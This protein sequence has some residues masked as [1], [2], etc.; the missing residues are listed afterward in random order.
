MEGRMNLSDEENELYTKLFVQCDLDGF[1]Y[2]SGNATSELF[3]SSGLS[4]D[5]LF[6]IWEIADKTN[7][8]QLDFAGFCV[9]LRLIGHVQ[10]YGPHALRDCDVLMNK[11][12]EELPFFS[13]PGPSS[14]SNI[15]QTGYDVDPALYF[16]STSDLDG[17]KYTFLQ[18]T[19]DLNDFLLGE[20]AR[21]FYLNTTNLSQDDLMHLWSLADI[22]KDGRLSFR[23]FCVMQKL[24][25]CLKL[26]GTMPHML[27]NPLLQFLEDYFPEFTPFEA[28]KV[29]GPYSPGEDAG[30]TKLPGE[31]DLNKHASQATKVIAEK[32]VRSE[33]FVGNEHADP[34]AP[35]R[36][37]PL[38]TNELI[39]Q[40]ENLLNT[41]RD[42]IN[43]EESGLD[44]AKREAS[45]VETK[46]KSDT[47]TL[48]NLLTEYRSLVGDSQNTSKRR[49]L[50]NN[51]LSIVQEQIQEM[52]NQIQN[53]R[54]GNVA[55]SSNIDKNNEEQSLLQNTRQM[56]LKQLDDET[57]LLKLEERELGEMSNTLQQLRRQ[58][59][60][61]TEKS[62]QLREC[63]SQSENATKTMLRSIQLQQGKILSVRNERISLLEE[64]LKLTNE[65]NRLNNSDNNL[66]S[67]GQ[68]PVVPG[69]SDTSIS[70]EQPSKPVSRNL[71]L[72]KKGI[73]VS[74][75]NLKV[76]DEFPQ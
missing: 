45:E 56:F 43:S 17:Y 71:N 35:P 25:E 40:C 21:N 4:D 14:Y 69:F 19:P 49:S 29:R 62:N 51:K 52:R 26:Y 50:L 8:G 16:I 48:E 11:T 47:K 27:P 54:V 60:L 10:I 70:S 32:G 38:V 57:N 59:D 74:S 12:P 65:I 76:G 33:A 66:N 63:L 13:Y 75:M 73:R 67:S 24:C 34:S 9:C 3:R 46:L 6:S 68:N 72:D 64:K 53:M 20:D 58:R 41:L 42:A 30:P 55:L 15:N 28:G 2:V 22:D 39:V 31:A 37:P 7:S 36:S 5:V 1:G 23:E 61:L 18:L 44:A